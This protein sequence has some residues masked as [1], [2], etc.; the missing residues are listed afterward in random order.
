[1]T[2]IEHS[3]PLPKLLCLK[4]N[5]SI[6]PGTWRKDHVRG[7]QGSG[8]GSNNKAKERR[9]FDAVICIIPQLMGGEKV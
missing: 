4:I 1:M 3:M 7:R 5:R 6:I 8:D 2:F 9:M